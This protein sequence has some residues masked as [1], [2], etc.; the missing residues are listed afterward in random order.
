MLKEPEIIINGHPLTA[1]EA[2][3]VRVSLTSALM[4]Y[5][6]PDALGTDEHGRT[7]VKH[8]RK[9]LFNVQSFMMDME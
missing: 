6:D 8:Y 5:S 7:M 9:A 2:M 3:A 4:G 1:A